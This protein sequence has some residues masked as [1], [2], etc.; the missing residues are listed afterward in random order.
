MTTNVGTELELEA[1]LDLSVILVAGVAWQKHDG[2]WYEASNYS[3]GLDSQILS[4]EAVGT[5]IGALTAGPQPRPT[6]TMAPPSRGGYTEDLGR[7][8]RA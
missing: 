7:R 8:P 2:R 4:Q 6:K 3:R 1:L 5:P